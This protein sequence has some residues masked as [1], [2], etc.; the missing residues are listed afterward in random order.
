[1]QFYQAVGEVTDIS[2]KYKR[3]M[4]KSANWNAN[5]LVRIEGVLVM[6]LEG[7]RGKLGDVNILLL[8]RPQDNIGEYS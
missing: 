1:M 7:K 3:C 2:K 6:V 4:I 5:N 8:G